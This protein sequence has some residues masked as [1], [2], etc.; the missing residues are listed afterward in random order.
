[1]QTAPVA[2]AT[3]LT[4][5]LQRSREKLVLTRE[6]ERRRIPRDLHDGLGPTL[7]SQTLKLDSVLEL[8]VGNDAQTAVCPFQLPRLPNHCRRCR[9]VR[10]RQRRL[11]ATGAY[12]PALLYYF[13]TIL[14]KRLG[15]AHFLRK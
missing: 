12:A 11:G 5:A 8:L 1:M 7:A 3:R 2:S 13:V 15:S 10:P 14:M 9:P 6:E 4:L